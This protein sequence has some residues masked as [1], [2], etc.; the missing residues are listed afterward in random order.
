M[1]LFQIKCVLAVEK[2]KNFTRAAEELHISQS[3]LSQ[4]ISNLESELGIK[5]FY[6]TTREVKLL[7]AGEEFV[8]YAGD[9][10]ERFKILKR[11]MEAYSEL[12]MSSISIGGMP[13]IRA[14]N[15]YSMITSFIR[16]HNN[17]NSEFIEGECL[18][19]VELLIRERID[20]AIIH[21]LKSYDSI[22][23]F[24]LFLDEFMILINASHPLAKKK[25]IDLE[26][27]KN[28]SFIL[29]SKDSASSQEFIEKCKTIGF[30]P[31]ILSKCGSVNT[32]IEFVKE[33]LGLAILSMRV[34]TANADSSI[35][36]AKMNPSINR[37]VSIATLKNSYKNNA[38]LKFIDFAKQWSA[39]KKSQQKNINN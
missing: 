3:S 6:R 23:F 37:T 24:D 20:V 31:Y 29:P 15:F 18:D 35:S 27:L 33:N 11:R 38:V 13:I 17:I 2:F 1:E 19:L 4:H 8:K 28:E 34:A 16:N 39:D 32:I 22:E 21:K 25:V 7:P 26:E 30:E 36:I 14:Y 5:L 10:I 12:E 9:V